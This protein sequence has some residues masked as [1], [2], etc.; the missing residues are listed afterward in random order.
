MERGEKKENRVRQQ[1]EEEEGPRGGRPLKKS[2]SEA[3][4]VSRDAEVAMGG[5]AGMRAPRQ[6]P[7][8]AA[9]SE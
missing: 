7:F 4:V 9:S 5:R 6:P 3:R 2:P 8:S 1:A